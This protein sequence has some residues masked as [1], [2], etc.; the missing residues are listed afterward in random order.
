MSILKTLDYKQRIVIAVS[1]A[2]AV[3][4][5]FLPEPKSTREQPSPV[6][7]TGIEQTLDTAYPLATS[8]PLAK[9]HYADVSESTASKQMPEEPPSELSISHQPASKN[10]TGQPSPQPSFSLEEEVDLN[11]NVFTLPAT[12]NLFSLPSHQT[13][14]VRQSPLNLE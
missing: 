1:L 14:P 10:Q 5:H 9:E 6:S 2:L 4:S 8:S 7:G 3:L 13:A 11:P 12:H